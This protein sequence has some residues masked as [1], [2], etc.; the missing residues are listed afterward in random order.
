MHPEDGEN[1]S[2]LGGDL[3]SLHGVVVEPAVVGEVKLGFRVGAPH[4]DAYEAHEQ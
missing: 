3:V 4:S 2:V 1:V